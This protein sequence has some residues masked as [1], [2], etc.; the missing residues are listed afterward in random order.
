LVGYDEILLL[1]ITPEMD[2]NNSTGGVFACIRKI[3]VSILVRRSG[4]LTFC[5]LIPALWCKS[6]ARNL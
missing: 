4:V 6:W 2:E 1:S 5:W 3:S